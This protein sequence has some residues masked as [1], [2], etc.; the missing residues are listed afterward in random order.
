[1]CLAFEPGENQVDTE[2]KSIIEQSKERSKESIPDFVML[3]NQSL[4]QISFYLNTLFLDFATKIVTVTTKFLQI[5]N[6]LK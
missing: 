5:C 2:I 6:P 4:S 1:M 3:P